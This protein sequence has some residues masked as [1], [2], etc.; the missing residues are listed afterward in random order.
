[1]STPSNPDLIDLLRERAERGAPRGSGAVLA[2]AHGDL[3]QAPAAP[4]SGHRSR[5]LAAAAVLLVVGAVGAA[6]V[7]RGDRDGA[8]ASADP[9]CAALEAQPFSP[10]ASD[11]DLLLYLEPGTSSTA[12]EETRARL[13]ADPRIERVR[14]VDADETAARFR[15][16]FSGDSEMIRSVRPEDLPTSFQVVLAP[17]VDDADEVARWRADPAIFEARGV[18]ELDART[19]D[20]LMWVAERP[21]E[22]SGGTTVFGFQPA[23]DVWEEHAGAVQAAADPEVAAAVEQLSAIV[24]E[25]GAPVGADHPSYDRAEAPAAVVADA[26]LRRCDLHV[27]QYL[28]ERGAVTDTTSVAAT[29][30]TTAP[31]VPGK[32]EGEGEGG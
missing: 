6:L 12:V 23:G 9:F 1:M 10:L 32:G 28:G 5:W 2:A 29:P 27:R 7:V 15:E 21:P 26:A 25:R 17:G 20:L 31:P 8:R 30:T 24:A 4:P 3:D 14:Y 18:G 16:L 22:P 11:A 19:F 13:E